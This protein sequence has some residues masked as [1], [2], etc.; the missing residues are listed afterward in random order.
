MDPFKVPHAHWTVNKPSSGTT[1]TGQPMDPP[2]LTDTLDSHPLVTYTGHSMD[3][4][5]VPNA[6]ESQWIP[7]RCYA[8]WTIKSPSSGTTHSSW[9]PRYHT[10]WTMIN[11]TTSDTNW[12]YKTNESPRWNCSLLNIHTF[13]CC[14]SILFWPPPSKACSLVFSIF[15]L[16]SSVCEAVHQ[17]FAKT[18]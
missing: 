18:L 8:H 17:R 15:S 14:L 12:Q 6:L 11:G 2:Q 9:T 1:H 4:L 5:Q 16:T 10:L 7:F 3:P 13:W